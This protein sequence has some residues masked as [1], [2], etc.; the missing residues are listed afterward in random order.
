MMPTE[1][2]ERQLPELLTEL[3]APRTPDYFDDLFRLTARTRQRPAW[4]FLERWLPMVDIARQPILTS[5]VPLRTIGLGLLL[6]ALILAA[7][8]AF[9]V[10]HAAQLARTVRA[11]TEWPGRVCHRMATSTPLIRSAA[12]P[13]RSSPDR[14]PTCGPSGRSMA[15]GSLS[16]DAWKAPTGPGLLYVAEAD[17]T[18]LVRVTPDALRSIEGYAFSPDGREI[19]FTARPTGSSTLLIAKSDGSSAPRS[20]VGRHSEPIRAQLSP[21]RRRR[22]RLRRSATRRIGFRAVRDQA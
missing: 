18:G 22:D 13:P 3:A 17:G 15:L 7:V 14:R 1:R 9:V 5:R 10:G 2:F 8:A 21:T 16:S 20:P 4:T 12:K 11:G 6:V 19:V